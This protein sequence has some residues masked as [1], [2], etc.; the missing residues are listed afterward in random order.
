MAARRAL[1]AIV[2]AVASLGCQAGQRVP[3]VLVGP[4][5][6]GPSREAFDALLDGV[7]S[8]GFTVEDADVVAGR[9]RVVSRYADRSTRIGEHAFVVQCFQTGHVQI[10]AVGPRVGHEGSDYVMPPGLRRELVALSQ[11]LTRITM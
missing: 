11:V 5:R 2:L 10:V 4:M 9:F 6:A 7:R 3:P 1:I 8:A